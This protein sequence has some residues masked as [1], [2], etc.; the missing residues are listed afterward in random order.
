MAY[1]TTH[2]GTGFNTGEAVNING[3]VSNLIAMARLYSNRRKAQ[4]RL[5][6]LD[7]RMLE[8]IGLTRADIRAHVWGR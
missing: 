4:K 2:T 3:Y 8:D 5:E 7:D 6:S 1:Q